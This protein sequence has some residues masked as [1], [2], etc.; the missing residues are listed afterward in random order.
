MELKVIDKNYHRNKY[1]MRISEALYLKQYKP[2][3][4][5]SS[6]INEVIRQ[7]LNFFF[8]YGKISQVQK[9]TKKYKK[10]LKSTKKY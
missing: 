2:S 4:N 5:A 8:F 10:A 1:K 9:S 7:V 3:L 6:N